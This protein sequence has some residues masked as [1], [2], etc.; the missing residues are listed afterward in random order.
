M[1][2][3]WRPNTVIT[4][5]KYRGHQLKDV[6]LNYILW[7]GGYRWDAEKHKLWQSVFRG[8]KEYHQNVKDY[9]ESLKQCVACNGPLVPI[10]SSRQN[11]ASHSDWE[12]RLLHKQCWQQAITGLGTNIFPQFD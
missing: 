1:N 5:G 2:Q 6:P 7:I 3:T 9:L 10:G 12:G 8:I 11:G 4:F